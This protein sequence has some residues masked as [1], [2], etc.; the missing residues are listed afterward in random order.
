MLGEGQGGGGDEALIG[1]LAMRLKSSRYQRAAVHLVPPSR[2]FPQH[3]GVHARLRRAMGEGTL[4]HCSAQPHATTRVYRSR[5]APC[6]ESQAVN[7]SSTI[8]GL[9]PPGTGECHGLAR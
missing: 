6:W 5:H 9:N 4:W 8:A 2:S 7:T 3:K 1:R